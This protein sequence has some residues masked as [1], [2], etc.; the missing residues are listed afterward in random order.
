MEHFEDQLSPDDF[1]TIADGRLAE[2]PAADMVQ[3]VQ[4]IVLA[5]LQR[6]SKRPT[7]SEVTATR[8]IIILFV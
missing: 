6:H 7:S 4:A 5:C 1:A 8:N 2:A 3:V